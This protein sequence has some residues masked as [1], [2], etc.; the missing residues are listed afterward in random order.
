LLGIEVVSRIASAIIARLYCR[1]L[2]HTYEEIEVQLFEA[3]QSVEL[4]G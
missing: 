2:T 1:S 3:D 4:S